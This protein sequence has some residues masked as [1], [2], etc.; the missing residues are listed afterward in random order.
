[1]EVAKTKA[2]E[3]SIERVIARSKRKHINVTWG[4]ILGIILLC[5]VALIFIY[6]LL[7][8]LDSSFRPMIEIFNLPPKFLT[9]DSHW[10]YWASYSLNNYLRAFR[11]FNIMTA[12]LM[13]LIVTISGVTLTLLLTSLC[14]YAFAFLRFPLKNFWF[15]LCLFTIMLPTTTMI[16]PNYKLMLNLGLLNNLLSI[17]IPPACSAWVVF[18]M[19]QFYIKLPYSLIESATMD[20]AGHFRIWWSIILPLS[21]PALAAVSIFQFRVFWNDFLYPIVFLRSEN[22]WTIPVKIKAMD[23]FNYNKPYDAIMATGFLFSLIP[24]VLFLI[25]QRHFIEGLSGGVKK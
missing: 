8:L 19:R 16:S 1:M 6:P 3:Y 4:Q 7:W 25:F 22:I 13:S 23:S 20:G 17:I 5:M 18:L 24:V 2:Y 14:G 10:P 9:F 21:W 11:E 12:F 15:Y